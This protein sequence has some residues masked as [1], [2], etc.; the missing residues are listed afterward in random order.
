MYGLTLDTSGS[1]IWWIVRDAEG[2][3]LFGAY[4]DN[5]VHKFDAQLL[6]HTVK[7]GNDKSI[8]FLYDFIYIFFLVTFTKP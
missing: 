1:R 8:F 7:L 3:R 6:P 2:C 5:E 4:L